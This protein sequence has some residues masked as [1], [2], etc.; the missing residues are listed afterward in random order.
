MHNSL[1][2]LLCLASGQLKE[3]GRRAV[4]A[5]EHL[6]RQVTVHVNVDTCLYKRKAYPVSHA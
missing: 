1:S 6:G 2:R 5:N 4:Y 3:H